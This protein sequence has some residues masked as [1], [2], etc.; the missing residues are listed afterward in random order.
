ML[1]AARKGVE[2][3]MNLLPHPVDD[4]ERQL[5]FP[6]AFCATISVALPE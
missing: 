2:R 3:A 6:V 1:F 5:R 4:L